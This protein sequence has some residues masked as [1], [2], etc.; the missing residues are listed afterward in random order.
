MNSSRNSLPTRE[1]A[2]YLTGFP[3][4]YHYHITS[5]IHPSPPPGTQIASLKC[6]NSSLVSFRDA[7]LDSELGRSTSKTIPWGRGV[8]S[9]YFPVKRAGLKALGDGPNFQCPVGQLSTSGSARSIAQVPSEHL[10]CVRLRLGT[11]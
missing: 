10:P 3:Q 2:L 11:W 5:F 9:Y 6:L 8:T 7:I 1:N 4:P